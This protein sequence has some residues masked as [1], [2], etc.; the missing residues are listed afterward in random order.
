MLRRSRH[1]SHRCPRP[2]GATRWRQR[3]AASDAAIRVALGEGGGGD[4][5]DDDD[6]DDGGDT[7]AGL[8][9][10]G[11]VAADEERHYSTGQVPAGDYRFTMTGTGDADLYVRIGA[12]PTESSW[13]CRPYSSGSDEVCTTTLAAPGQVHVMVRGYAQTSSFELVGEA[14]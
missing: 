7:W 1:R 14:E 8:S 12:A 4:D 3:I 2:H 5:D 11:T 6:D 13:D 9:D 10:T